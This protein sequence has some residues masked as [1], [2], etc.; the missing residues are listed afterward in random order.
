[1]IR[2]VIAF[3][4]ARVRSI[5]AGVARAAAALSLQS[6]PR[7]QACGCSPS[8]KISMRLAPLLSFLFALAAG[9]AQAAATRVD[10]A[11]P[12]GAIGGRIEFPV[13]IAPAMRICAL[14]AAARQCIDAPAGRTLYRIEHLPDGDYQVV[15]RVDSVATPIAG[16]VQAVQCIAAP[17]ADP[18]ATLRIV[19]GKEIA[20]ANLNGFYARRD[21]FP[22]LP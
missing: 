12:Q 17:C 4:T 1:M 3:R 10:P 20:N 21:E 14:S 13:G 22:P 11:L 18:L 16:H 15:A 6:P 5:A 19:G 7:S 9:S 2:R 8:R